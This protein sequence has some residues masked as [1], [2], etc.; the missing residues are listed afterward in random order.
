MYCRE[1][2]RVYLRVTKELACT[3]SRGFNFSPFNNTHF[4]SFRCGFRT[5]LHF[6]RS[7]RSSV[8]IATAYELDCPE[9][10]SQLRTRLSSPLQTGPW[11]HPASYTMGTGFSR[12]KAAG[13][14][15]WPNTTSSAE[16]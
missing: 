5:A 9:I 6:N 8:S 3:E 7:R 2:P 16:V 1:E 12:G 11:A 10:A 14:W 4:I 13:I 15:Y